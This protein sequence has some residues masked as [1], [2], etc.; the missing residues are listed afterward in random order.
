MAALTTLSVTTCWRMLPLVD[1]TKKAPNL[2]FDG[3][4]QVDLNVWYKK[5]ALVV[6]DVCQCLTLLAGQG[7]SG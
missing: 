2:F 4:V 5:R 3:V 7:A 6:G 1:D